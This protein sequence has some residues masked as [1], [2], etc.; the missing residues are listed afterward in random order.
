MPTDYASVLELVQAIGNVAHD[1]TKEGASLSNNVREDLIRNAERLAIA[2]REPE[3]N[4]Y[5]QATQ[6]V[7]TVRVE[8]ASGVFSLLRLSRRPRTLL[9]G[10]L[11]TWAFSQKYRSPAAASM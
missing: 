4:L 8:I 10:Q 9:S 6:V 3:E 5:F 2:A 11:S 7:I 1:L